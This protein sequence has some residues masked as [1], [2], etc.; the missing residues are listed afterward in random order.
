MWWC[1]VVVIRTSLHN[2]V[3]FFVVATTTKI[4]PRPDRDE[5][6]GTGVRATGSAHA[7]GRLSFGRLANNITHLHTT[8]AS[9]GHGVPQRSYNSDALRRTRRT[10]RRGA[11]ACTVNGARTCTRRATHDA[12]RR[13][14]NQPRKMRAIRHKRARSACARGAPPARAD[15]G[16][17]DPTLEDRKDRRGAAV[18]SS[19]RPGTPPRS[20][21]GPGRA[22]ASEGPEPSARS[23]CRCRTARRSAGRPSGGSRRAHH[24]D[25]T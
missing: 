20:R 8:P 22:R 17:T 18:L 5:S 16:A 7:G 12:R 6:P 19:S 21:R 13:R 15:L 3:M 9:P 14:P 23:P 10:R 24:H 4:A 11:R 2:K 1:A 25:D